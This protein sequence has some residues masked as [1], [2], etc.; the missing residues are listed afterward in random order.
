LNHK[1]DEDEEQL[2]R[3]AGFE[4]KEGLISSSSDDSSGFMD[5]HKE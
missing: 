3:V 2:M 5:E 1:D 4:R